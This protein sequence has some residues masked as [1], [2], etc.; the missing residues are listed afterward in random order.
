MCIKSANSHSASWTYCS[1][2]VQL[3]ILWLCVNQAHVVTS[4]DYTLHVGSHFSPYEFTELNILSV[5]SQLP[6]SILN[7]LIDID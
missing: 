1:I 3:Q 6:P 5:G 4:L 7:T 2:V